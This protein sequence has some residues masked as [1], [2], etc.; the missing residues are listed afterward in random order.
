MSSTAARRVFAA[1]WTRFERKVLMLTR[2]TYRD[3]C[4]DGQK[5]IKGTDFIVPLAGYPM[6]F[7][8]GRKQERRILC[9][10]I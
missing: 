6:A 5:A 4:L 1:R 9:G 7:Y 3:K 8:K 10:S 2:I